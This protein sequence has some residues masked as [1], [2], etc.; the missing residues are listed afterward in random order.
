[1]T[2]DVLEVHLDLAGVPVT[3]V[4]TAGLRERSDDAIEAEGMRRAREQTSAADL[5]LKLI[6]L[7]CIDFVLPPDAVDSRQVSLL[8]GTKGDLA[9]S[10]RA[11]IDLAVSARTGDGL[12]AL[13][14]L[15]ADRLRALVWR[16]GGP[17]PLVTR[18]RQRAALRDTLTALQRAAVA[19]SAELI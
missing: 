7:S 2:R 10:R 6:D 13:E 19:R 9:N 1:T 14:A 3:L 8:T 5:V 17:A 4:D 11:G 12:D 16:D 18:A 15:L